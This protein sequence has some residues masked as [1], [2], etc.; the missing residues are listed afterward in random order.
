MLRTSAGKWFWHVVAPLALGSTIYVLARP[1]GLIVFDW[2]DVVGLTPMVDSLRAATPELPEWVLYSLP[3]GLWSYAFSA[4]VSLIWRAQRI[5]R[6]LWLA[7][8]SATCLASEI[9]Q[10]IKVV[11]GTFSMQDLTANAVGCFLGALI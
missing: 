8:V 9:G 5:E 2:L 10:A 3:T 1:K 4:S 6:R 11:P 7:V